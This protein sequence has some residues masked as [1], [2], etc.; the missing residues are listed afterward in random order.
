MSGKKDGEI[1]SAC[2]VLTTYE[3]QFTN[4]V[5]FQPFPLKLL[6]LAWLILNNRAEHV[7][8]LEPISTTIAAGFASVVSMFFIGD[9]FNAIKCK[10]VECCTDAWI[11]PNFTGNYPKVTI[12]VRSVV[13]CYVVHVDHTY[14]Y[15]LRKTPA[16]KAKPKV[17]IY[18]TK[19]ESKNEKASTTN[20]R[21]L[22]SSSINDQ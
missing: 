8:S 18:K 5:M 15:I 21:F 2:Y 9:G 4:T 3:I 22:F 1:I 19:L 6:A 7:E 20:L 13:N 16:F 10:T 17:Q 12:F 11:N 14:W